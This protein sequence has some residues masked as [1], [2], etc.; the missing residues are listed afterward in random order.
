ML[1]LVAGRSD[2]LFQCVHPV[3]QHF[4]GVHKLPVITFE[5]FDPLDELGGC[6]LRQ[7]HRGRRHGM[8]MALENRTLRAHIQLNQLIKHLTMLHSLGPA[9]FLEALAGWCEKQR[10]GESTGFP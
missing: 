5:S 4:K 2:A 3:D 1:R 10:T 7:W 8:T 6:F 9:E